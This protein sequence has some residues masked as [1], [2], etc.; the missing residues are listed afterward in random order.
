MKNDNPL[1][2]KSYLF[3]VQLIKLY[4]PATYESSGFSLFQ[5][6]I[7]SGTSIGANIEEAQ[8]AQSKRDFIAK[9]YISLKESRET[10]YWLRLLR[11]TGYITPTDAK[12]L[13]PKCEE[14]LK[15]LTSALITSRRNL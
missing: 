11:D 3:S 10:R 8:A 7:R 14:L 2:D 12:D 13:L 4:G 6:L 15:M 1:V 9:L 5:Q